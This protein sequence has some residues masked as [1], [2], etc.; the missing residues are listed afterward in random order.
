MEMDND[1]WQHS[2]LI[3]QQAGI[4]RLCLRLQDE[5][6]MDVNLVLFC[7]WLGATGLVVSPKQ[8]KDVAEQVEDWRHQVVVPL[9]TLRRALKTM[10]D[11]GSVIPQIKLAELKAEQHQQAL[12]WNYYKDCK[13]NFTKI[14]ATWYEP[15]LEGQR[16]HRLK[17]CEQLLSKFP[18]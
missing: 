8:L 14:K 16:G 10:V 17:A 15:L 3:Y 7:H 9:R 11:V 6:D 12:M 2:L 1:F 4:E 5:F 13:E 18:S